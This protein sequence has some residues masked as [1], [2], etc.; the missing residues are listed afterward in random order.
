MERRPSDVPGQSPRI[1]RTCTRTHLPVSRSWWAA[2]PLWKV[3]K[4]SWISREISSYFFLLLVLFK[5][6]FF[7]ETGLAPGLRALVRGLL[8]APLLTRD[9]GTLQVKG[10]GRPGSPLLCGPLSLGIGARPLT[11]KELFI[12]ERMASARPPR[13]LVTQ[14]QKGAEKVPEVLLERAVSG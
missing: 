1:M 6:Q 11:M 3:L 5:D 9:P 12:G 14:A 8:R 10:A 2:F 4:G 13:T 7:P